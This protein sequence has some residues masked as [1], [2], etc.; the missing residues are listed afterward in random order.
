MA[1]TDFYNGNFYIP[2]IVLY[3]T[4]EGLTK[5][6]TLLIIASQQLAWCSRFVT[7]VAD[8]NDGGKTTGNNYY[9]LMVDNLVA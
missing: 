9:F 2:R 7:I 6:L 4:N 5:K 8:I 3:L 1:G